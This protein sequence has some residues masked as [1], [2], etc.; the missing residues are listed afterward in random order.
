MKYVPSD[1]YDRF[2]ITLEL[3]TNGKDWQKGRSGP[4][5]EV[6]PFLIGVLD[7]HM[8]MGTNVYWRAFGEG[9]E[10][11]FLQSIAEVNYGDEKVGEA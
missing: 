8:R 5:S 2:T 3:S 7:A 10:N 1:C 6:W 9:D 11:P 4:P